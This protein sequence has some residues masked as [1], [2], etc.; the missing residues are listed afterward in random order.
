MEFNI[1]HFISAPQETPSSELMDIN[2]FF[3]SDERK[4]IK[5]Q[6]KDDKEAIKRNAEIISNTL[7]RRTKLHIIDND[8]FELLSFCSTADKNI[9]PTQKQV[10]QILK[11]SKNKK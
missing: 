2:K 5:V 3:T 6:D 8:F 4:I 9:L 11:K 10:K 1:S 7:Q